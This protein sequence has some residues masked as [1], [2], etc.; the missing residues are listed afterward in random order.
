MVPCCPPPPPPRPRGVEGTRRGG[1]DELP[2]AAGRERADEAAPP[3][4]TAWA[5]RC[6]EHVR[7]EQGPE[8][9]VAS[10]S[11]VNCCELGGTLVVLAE[12]DYGDEYGIC[13]GPD[14]TASTIPP[15]TPLARVSGRARI[16]N[17]RITDTLRTA[18]S[19][20]GLS[21]GLLSDDI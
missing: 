1:K 15:G 16:T 13:L 14:G 11:S 21:L 3:G 9:G 17:K 10:P 7:P 6:E 18:V 20:L 4:A 8:G 2:A 19:Y 5:R 12:G